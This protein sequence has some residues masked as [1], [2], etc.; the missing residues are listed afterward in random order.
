L[1]SILDTHLKGTGLALSQQLQPSSHVATHPPTGKH[2]QNQILVLDGVRAI[3]CLIILSYHMSLLIRDYG[4]LPPLQ[5]TNPLV[6]ILNY[7]NAFFAEFGESGVILFFVLSG[8]L[9]FLPYAKALLLAS[10]WPSVRRYYLRRIFRILPGYYVA[11]LLILSF[12]H[13]E[14]LNV[15]HWH[16]LWTFLTF[17][18][19]LN[20]SSQ[21][22]VPFWTLA[23]EFQFYLL[24]PIIAWLFSLVVSGDKPH[25]RMRKL[26]ICLLILTI[27]GVVTRYLGLDVANTSPIA[28]SLT[29]PLFN[30]LKPYVYGDTGKY[31]DVFVVGMFLA[32]LYTFIQSTF[33]GRRWQAILR[34]SNPFILAAGIALLVLLP[35][36][37]M[38]ALNYGEYTLTSSFS[39]PHI[40][41]LVTDW[42]QWQV[43]GYSIGYALC[44]WALMF[45]T[46]RLKRPFE[47]SLL[48][49]FGSISFSLYMWHLPFMFIFIYT[50][51]HNI[52]TQ[53]WSPIAQYS[54]FWCW[55]LVVIIPISAAF[56]RWVE[57]PGVRLGE[58]LIAATQ[59]NL[60]SKEQ[61]SSVGQLSSVGRISSV[62]T[63]LAPVR[64]AWEASTS[65]Q[66]HPIS[67]LNEAT[68]LTH[69][70]WQFKGHML[71]RE[72]QR[73]TSHNIPEPLNRDWDHI[74]TQAS[75][76]LPS[77]S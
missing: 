72:I 8:F 44:L 54:L 67:S 18:M 1:K 62:G 41:Q 25:Q 64:R 77:F 16:D 52:H 19:S 55:T 53:A 28:C 12:F 9:L 29:Y 60:L 43:I 70:A 68:T 32:M 33:A 75:P 69:T 10:P 66:V 14:L 61:I 26:T 40:P 46:A 7:I 76:I 2:A 59:T 36:Q 13:P 45:G 24:L 73:T 71:V 31:L 20:L 74:I 65:A 39:D 47:G 51:A 11:L 15:N 17:T 34:Q 30:T 5:D 27:W 38:T 50:I 3:A 56:Y 23:I 58:R 48:R 4:I 6:I 22:N 21:V 37:H 57:K 42:M 35:L 49:W 63:G